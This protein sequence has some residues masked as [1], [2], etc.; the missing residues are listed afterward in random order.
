MELKLQDGSVAFT[1]NWHVWKVADGGI[2]AELPAV[3]LEVYEVS[4]GGPYTWRAYS[5]STHVHEFYGEA[6]TTHR[7]TPLAQSS[8]SYETVEAAK[9]EATFWYIYGTLDYTKSI[10]IYEGEYA[11]RLD[12]FE[13]IRDKIQL[14]TKLAE[15][16][17][18]VTKT[19]MYSS[20]LH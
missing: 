7:N 4:P 2:Y 18:E 16:A 15:G 6:R 19:P 1:H 17:T 13:R 11:A 5:I 10:E 9:A 8:F 3:N 12:A 20:D 14:S